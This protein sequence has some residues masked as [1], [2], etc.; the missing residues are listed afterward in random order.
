MVGFVVYWTVT[1][2]HS[3]R[4]DAAQ[5]DVRAVKLANSPQS[6]AVNLDVIA[7]ADFDSDGDVD[8]EDFGRFQKCLTDFG[9]PYAP[10]CLAGDSNGDGAVD[11]QDAPA[12]INCM[13]GPN[14]PP[15]C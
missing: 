3:G 1:N 13:N 11:F 5:A 9:I 10:G 2:E 12:F 7:F 14:R 6:I 15:G 8:Q 4:V